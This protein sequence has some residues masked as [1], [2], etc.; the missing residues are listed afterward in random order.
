MAKGTTLVLEGIA[1][2]AQVHTPGKYGKYTVAIVPT[3]EEQIAS[4]E[5]LGLKA[6]TK[7]APTLETALAT[8]GLTGK[9]VFDA[10]RKVEF[11]N[12]KTN[13]VIKL[14]APVVLD[15]KLNP[16]K[17]LVGNGS[18][19]KVAGTVNQYM[20]KEGVVSVFNMA[21]VQV[22]DLV[23]YKPTSTLTATDGFDS[24]KLNTTEM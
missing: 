20:G 24:T 7:I 19:V 15:A 22:L 2:F 18:R 17:N 16:I 4:A 23:E 8:L 11:V 13:E 10:E 3:T 14:G 1:F 21:E 9:K 12:K 5:R 6:R